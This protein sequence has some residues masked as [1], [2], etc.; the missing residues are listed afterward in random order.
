MLNAEQGIMHEGEKKQEQ[1]RSLSLQKLSFDSPSDP[2]RGV[3]VLS[4]LKPYTRT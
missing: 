1:V 3:E 2:A 4:T